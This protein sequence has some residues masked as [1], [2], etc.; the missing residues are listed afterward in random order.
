MMPLPPLTGGLSNPSGELVEPRLGKSG[1]SFDGLRTGVVGA[2][3][4]SE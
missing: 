1:A 2:A 3:G 4:D